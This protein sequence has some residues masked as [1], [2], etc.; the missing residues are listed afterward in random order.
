MADENGKE[1]LTRSSKLFEVRASTDSLWQEI[2][3]QFYPE[4]AEFTSMRLSQE[5]FADHLYATEPVMMRRDLGN[6]ISAMTRPGGRQWGKPDLDDEKLRKNTAVRT[7][8]DWLGAVQWRAMY[9]PPAMFVRATKECDHDL[10]TFGNAVLSIEPNMNAGRLLYRAHHLKDCAWAEN[11]EGVVDLLHRKI[12]MTARGIGQMF[13]EPGDKLHESIGKAIE[14]ESFKEFDLL[15][16]M[17]PVKD[18]AYVTRSRP[19]SNAAF[20]SIYVDTANKSVIRERPSWEFRYVVQ[21]WATLPNCA[22]AISPA[23]ITALPEAR[24]MQTLARIVMEAGEKSID[25]PLKATEEAVRGEIN[26]FA[27][28]TTWVDREY[29]ERLGPAV[30][31]IQLGKDAGLGIHLLDRNIRTLTNA[32]YLNKLNLPSE[33][34]KTA[35]ETAQLVEENLRASAPLFEPMEQNNAAILNTTYEILRR[36]GTFAPGE[37]PDVMKGRNFTFSFSN[38]LHDAIERAKV[39][40]YQGMTQ[41][42]ALG[43]QFD[44]TITQD[45]DMRQAFRD[46][47]QGSGAPAAWLKD[48][49]AADQGAA[50][51]NQ[52]AML[53]EV[54]GAANAGGQAAESVGKGVQALTAKPAANSN[55]KA[56]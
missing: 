13:S 52:K 4:R 32:W 12:R 50:E 49:E 38:P 16:V 27:G 48:K 3:D 55:R 8:L 45:V 28:G 35:Y 25:P 44:P 20:V 47:V 9:D 22:Y 1:L 5:G 46:A 34:G 11:Y 37:M 29:D 53:A 14:K 41:L 43:A 36:V 10:V 15:H 39:L 24:M 31:P 40:Q 30:E 19:P 6:A 26:L 33:Q 42:I 56:A 2:A 17:M 23:T 51:M 7:Y 54:M 18:Y 21:R